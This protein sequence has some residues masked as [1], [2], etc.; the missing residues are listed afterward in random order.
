MVSVGIHIGDSAS[1]R[2]SALPLAPP[3]GAPPVIICP[4]LPLSRSVPLVYLPVGCLRVAVIL[5]QAVSRAVSPS[6]LSGFSA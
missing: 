2:R 1:S 4:S 3:F 6:I 5:D